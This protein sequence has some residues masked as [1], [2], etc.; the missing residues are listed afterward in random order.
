L[1]IKIYIPGLLIVLVAF[2]ISLCTYK[3]YG[4]AYDEPLQRDIGLVSYNYVRHGND[5]LFRF[6]DRDHGV[7]FELPLIMAEKICKLSD[8]RYIYLSRH[9][10]THIFFLLSVFCGYV[11]LLKLYQ[12]QTIAI[13]GTLLLLAHPRIYAHSFFNTKDLPF[14]SACIISYL[15][16]YLSVNKLK[17]QYTTLHALVC[18]YATAI[19]ALG[20]MLPAVTIGLIPIY[21]LL[22]QKKHIK[23]TL[24]HT[25]LFSL[26]YFLFL[27]LCWPLLWQKPLHH[28][29]ETLQSLSKFR[30]GGNVLFMGHV[31]QSNAIPR[32]YLP[33]WFA[34]STPIVYA[35]LSV[36]A[37]TYIIASFITK[38]YKQLQEK[39]RLFALVFAL[40]SVLPVAYVIYTRAVVYDDWRHLY[41][42]YPSIV[43]C[44]CYLLYTLKDKF[45]GKLIVG[46]LV[47]QLAVVIIDMAKLHPYQQIYFNVLAPK[48]P[49]YL[50]H[51]FEMEYWGTSY[52][53][54]LEYILTNDNRDSIKVY[55]LWPMPGNNKMILPETMRKRI[56]IVW[57]EDNPNYFI[58]VFRGHPADFTG[59][60]IICYEKRLQKNTIMRIYRM[61]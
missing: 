24:L 26:L 21:V 23:N 53:E 46:A 11:L 58:T 54:A 33:I 2:I 32:S 4:V 56:N 35:L 57:K 47:V 22:T 36:G 52:K 31:Y 49:E 20:V 29:I 60:G 51:H 13:V 38:P 43:L 27:W 16:L 39:T 50:R 18:A 59:M 3:D 42:V 48:K 45:T 61:N 30:W 12:K 19:R 6:Y 5:S 8:S 44:I 15:T 1:N 9:I 14:L 41:F 10:I 28:L 17:W 40:C 34:I 25:T 37:V 7:A 55:G